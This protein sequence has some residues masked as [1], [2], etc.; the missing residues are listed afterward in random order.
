VRINNLDGAGFVSISGSF[1]QFVNNGQRGVY[2]QS[3]GAV[4]MTNVTASNNGL[5]GAEISNSNSPLKFPVTVKNSAFN[6][7]GGNGGIYIR[8]QGN[9]LI[10]LVNAS[11]NPGNWAGG[12]FENT[13]DTTGLKTITIQRSIFS[14]N[15]GGGIGASS[16]GT[17]TLNNVSVNYNTSWHG[18]SLNNQGGLGNIVFNNSLGENL[19][20]GN[21]QNGL[22][23]YTDHNITLRSVH[24]LF[25]GGDGAYLNQ[26][27]GPNGST[28]IISST[29]SNN[30]GYGLNLNSVG[31][32]SMDKVEARSNGSTGLHIF[33]INA[34]VDIYTTTLTR[35][36][37]SNN[38]YH[39]ISIQSSGLVTLNTFK[40]FNNGENGL[41]V[42][43]NIGGATMG[44]NILSQY[45]ANWTSGN[46]KSGAHII[47]SG[48]VSVSKIVA[49]GN[50]ISTNFAGLF[51]QTTNNQNITLTC[52]LITG[53]GYHGLTANLGTGTLTLNGVTAYGNDVFGGTVD[54]DIFNNVGSTVITNSA[55]CGTFQ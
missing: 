22:N 11:Y 46:Y 39:G 51:I 41:Y 7:N 29:F 18:V 4:S 9:I 3:N 31:S 20:I 30:L 5:W 35:V 37:A 27:N 2:I 25:N 24:T 45:G 43:N 23:I 6:H 50:G 17:I 53:N 10:D 8:S 42:S 48:P 47:S 49:L 14:F 12:S 26:V 19:L 34:L 36:N 44:V 13:N 38:N 16:Y 55:S 1:N 32:I 15:G 40:I 54:P 52:A 28:T 33:A 21:N